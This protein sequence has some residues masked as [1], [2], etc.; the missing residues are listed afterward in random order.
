MNKQ[1]RGKWWEFSV[2]S[3]SDATCHT[4]DR[5]QTKL[6]SKPLKQS[7]QLFRFRLAAISHSHIMSKMTRAP[8]NSL[9]PIR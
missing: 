4:V 1:D 5:F 8:H 3:L 7:I 6:H 2:G 9:K